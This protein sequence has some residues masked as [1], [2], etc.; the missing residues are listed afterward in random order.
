MHRRLRESLDAIQRFPRLLLR[1]LRRNARLGAETGCGRDRSRTR[2]ARQKGRREIGARLRCRPTPAGPDPASKGTI[3][4]SALPQRPLQ[5]R[6]PKVEQLRPEPHSE[7]PGNVSLGVGSP[8]RGMVVVVFS[9]PIGVVAGKIGEDQG[10]KL[11]TEKLSP[12]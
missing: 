9:A 5:R 10:S 1:G 8:S 2:T 3:L 12:V 4:G 6:Y 11:F 7:C